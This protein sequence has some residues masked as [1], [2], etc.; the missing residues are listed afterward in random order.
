SGLSDAV[1]M[2]SRDGV[3][4]DRPFMEAWV[5]PGMDQR[6]W[7]HRSCTP[8]PG[9]VQTADEWSMYLSENYGW[10]TNRLRRVVMRPHGFASVR[11]GYRGGEL[12]TRP[13]LLEGAAL[14]LNYATSAAGSLRV[15][16]QDESGQPLPKYALEEMDPIYGDQLDAPVA[17]KTGGDLSGLKGRAVRLRVVL[18]DAD[19]FAVRAA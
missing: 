17:W 13:L 5:R 10:S 19:L 2:S 6:N 16:L 9:L 11:A 15:E 14:R 18:Q 3:H 8:A 4:W 12:L 1:F 7:S